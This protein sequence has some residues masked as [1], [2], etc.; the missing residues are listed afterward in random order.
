[1]QENPWLQIPA[2]DYESHM[3]DVGQ[4]SVLRELFAAVYRETRPVRL[5]IL[6]C[7]TGDDFVSIDPGVTTTVV[8]VDVN[9]EYIAIAESRARARGQTLHLVLGDVLEA[10][11]PP[12]G[13][14]LV[15]AALLLEYVEPAALLDRVYEWLSAD[16]TFSLVTQEPAAGL[17]GV[18]NTR[19]QSLGILS[20]RM[21]LRS[22][23]EVAALGT[24]AGFR[25]ASK[26][27]IRLPTGKSLVS[28]A[29]KKAEG[30]ADPTLRHR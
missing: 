18:S 15:H 17:P 27:E 25:V 30:L 21:T 20:G 26:R 23:D 19:Y 5:A 29:L 24:R 1:M 8:G 10:E 16:G 22:A 6:G 9:P 4:S 13:Y 2:Q 28:T 3:S 7:T 14:D 11:L 12:G